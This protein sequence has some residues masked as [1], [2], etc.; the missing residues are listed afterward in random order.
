VTFPP[1]LAI[2]LGDPAGIGPEVVIR[3][4]TSDGVNEVCRP[5]VVGDAEIVEATISGLDASLAVHRIDRVSEARHTIGTV[6]VV[7]TGTTRLADLRPGELSAAGGRAAYRAVALATQLA[8]ERQVSGIVTGPLNKE[9]LNL[10]GYHYPGHTELLAELTGSDHVVMM[11]RCERL[12]VTLV[13]IHVALRAAVDLVRRESVLTSIRLT[14]H[15]MADL[16]YGRARIAVTGLNPHA[17]EG[18]LFGHEDTAEIRPAVDDATADGILATGPLPADTVFMRALAGEFDAVV[19]MTHDQGLAAL[20]AICFDSAVNI[21]L[22]LPIVRTSPDHG[23]AY[24]RAWQWRADGASMRAAI[25]MASRLAD[26]QA[27]RPAGRL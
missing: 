27:G 4:L 9:G 7:D 12:T 23:T 16:G 15:A 14:H 24:D 5:V 2:T 19:A 21:T 18:G 22:G 8:L 26:R 25:D 1:L 6:D 10:A 3:A 13:T 11:L 17:G 20:K